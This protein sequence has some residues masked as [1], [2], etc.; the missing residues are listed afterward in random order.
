MNT[1]ETRTILRIAGTL[2]LEMDIRTVLYMSERKIKKAWLDDQPKEVKVIAALSEDVYDASSDIVKEYRSIPFPA[3]KLSRFSKLRSILITAL[4]RGFISDNDKIICVNGSVHNRAPFDS[5]NVIDM[6]KQ[7][8]EL[9]LLREYVSKYGLQM[10]V[11]ASIMDIA[12]EIGAFGREGHSI[13]TIFIVGDSRNVLGF[14]KQIALNPFKG[15]KEKDRNIRDHFNKENVLEF[16]KLD[17]AFIVRKDGIV[18]AAARL[19]FM[20]R[21]KVSM[22][23]GL[24]SRHNAAAYITKKTESVGIVVSESTG[25]VSVYAEGKQLFQLKTSLKMRENI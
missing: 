2:A 4:S 10:N 24:G 21:T 19:L 7:F 11:M 18:S 12:I 13:G 15:H 1:K 6:S 17:G 22:L 5:I 9:K 16:C 14:S 25:S 8:R 23:P 3:S 20:P